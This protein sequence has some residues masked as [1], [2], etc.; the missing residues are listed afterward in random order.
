MEGIPFDLGCRK[1]YQNLRFPSFPRSFQENKHKMFFYWCV[2]IAFKF[3]ND[4]ATSSPTRPNSLSLISLTFLSKIHI[5]F[6][7]Y[8]VPLYLIRI[9][10]GLKLFPLLLMSSCTITQTRSFSFTERRARV[11]NTPGYFWG[12]TEFESRPKPGHRNEI[13]LNTDRQMLGA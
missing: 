2:G 5:T 8:T 4:K 3:I 7:V 1:S 6:P 13:F 12:D 10:H 9:N 11:A